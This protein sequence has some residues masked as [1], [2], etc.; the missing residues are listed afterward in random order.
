MISDSRLMFCPFCGGNV[1]QVDDPTYIREFTLKCEKCD[2]IFCL[3]ALDA[4]EDDL[5]T[6]FNT[7]WQ[8]EPITPFIDHIDI[9]EFRCGACAHTLTTQ[10][11]FGDTVLF[12]EKFSY[13]P[14][15]GRKVDWS[16]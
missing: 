6:A 5:E 16:E 7:R 15:C 2:M 12:V 8:D 14:A 1:R 3:D 10:N 4:T 13:C 11:R 9:N